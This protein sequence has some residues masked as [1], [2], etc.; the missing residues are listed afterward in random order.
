LTILSEGLTQEARHSEHYSQNTCC[1]WEMCFN[2]KAHISLLWC[3]QYAYGKTLNEDRLSF[4]CAL[5]QYT[6]TGES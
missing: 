3:V 2:T 6:L 4:I 5:E 1:H